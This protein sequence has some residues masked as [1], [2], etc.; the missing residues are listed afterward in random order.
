MLPMTLRSALRQLVRQP[1]HAFACAVTLALAVAAGTASL[2]V[3]KQAFFEPLPYLA[4]DDLVS[5]FTHTETWQESP[6]SAHV[7]QDMRASAVPLTGYTAVEPEGVAYSTADATERIIGLQVSPEFFEIFARP[8]A[9]RVWQA[10]ERDVV[11]ISS[12]FHQRALASAAD[13]VGRTVTL[14]GR[15][16]AV[17]GI[18]PPSFTMPLWT[19]AEYVRPID[20][21][22]YLDGVSRASR[23]LSVFARRIPGATQASVDAQLDALSAQLVSAYPAEHREQRWW[24]QPLRHTLV[25]QARPALLGTGAAAALLLL[26]VCANL[27]GISAAR[28]VGLRQQL[29]IQGALGATRARLLAERMAEALLIAVAG[30][31]AGVWL[32]RALFTAA[33]AFQQDVL[34]RMAT[35]HIDNATL[36][37]GLVTGVLCGTAAAVLPF[38]IILRRPASLVG[39]ARGATSSSS[40]SALRSSLVV[41]QVAVAIVLVI[42]AALLVRTVLHLTQTSLGFRSDGLVTMSVGLSG[43]RYADE[44]AQRALERSVLER[45]RAMPGVQAA[46]ASL[47]IP[48][49]GGT[50]AN[51]FIRGRGN[52]PAAE[53]PYFS[54]A[55]GFMQ[56][57]DIPLRAGRDLAITDVEG[58]DGAILISETMARTFWPDG[59]A[60]G[61]RI[62]L[63]GGTPPRAD[64]PWMVVVGVVGDVRQHGPTADVLPTAYGSTLQFS[65]PARQF[66]VRMAAGAAAP[67]A[68]TLQRAVHDVDPALAVANIQSVAVLSASRTASQ[69]L[70][71][72]ALVFFGLV[73]TA[74]C[75]FGLYAVVTLTSRLRRR[76]YA[77]RLAVGAQPHGLRLIVL[78]QALLLGAAGVAIGLAVAFAG[79][80]TLHGLLHG[81][82]PL[83][84]RS[85]ALAAALM[86][87]IATLAAWN[88]ARHAA[89]VAA[90][91][92]LKEP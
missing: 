40:L 9:G 16:H 6:V 66:T 18:M 85:F 34:Q 63:G 4:G 45:L 78:R 62:Y 41:L 21:R 30:S 60:V 3:V 13:A 43:E 86:L 57:F 64:T 71:M 82:Q 44:D 25:G 12:A 39:S 80:R 52:E 65:W 28:A 14:D 55:P 77:I 75:A 46:T 74:L 29:A 56:T 33:A 22:E 10:D 37:L 50:R 53:V 67:D 89:R 79:T 27:A 84:P 48:I 92:V 23:D 8:A 91:E 20:M 26:I 32:G 72:R 88:P 36:V 87:L 38:V 73:A 59:D 11:V 90:A 35:L 17:I 7:L 76:E 83:D 1:F 69:R 24:A 42:G 70:V 68:R 49:I 2:A 58:T 31:V 47:G 5:V 54:V 51:L 15:P 61:A 81:V 19:N